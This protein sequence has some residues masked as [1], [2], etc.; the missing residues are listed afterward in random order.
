MKLVFPALAAALT[1]AAAFPAAAVPTAID[2]GSI[3]VATI[4]DFESSLINGGRTQVFSGLT[5]T[6]AEVRAFESEVF[7]GAPADSCLFGAFIEDVRTFDGFQS[8]TTAFGFQLFHM[9]SSKDNIYVTVSG[10]SGSSNFSISSDGYFGFF[11]PLRLHSVVFLNLGSAGGGFTNY[12][13]DD[14]ITG[15]VAPVPLPSG[16]LLL[17]SALGGLGFAARRKRT[18]LA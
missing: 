14:V 1:A 16:V 9:L 15:T 8:G 12:S 17:V 13:F 18:P 5:A 4:E 7:C 6:V 10:D 11:D 3:T 2:Y